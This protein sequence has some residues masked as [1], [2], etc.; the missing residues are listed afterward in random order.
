M[1]NNFHA[2]FFLNKIIITYT[3]N[4]VNRYRDQ[5]SIEKKM[6]DSLQRRN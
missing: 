3:A 1:W 2:T 5:D 4:Q 6:S